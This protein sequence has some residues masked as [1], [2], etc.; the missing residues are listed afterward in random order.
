VIESIWGYILSEILITFRTT[1]DHITNPTFQIF[2]S[3][4]FSQQVTKF[5]IKPSRSL[6]IR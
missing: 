3:F 5:V 1:F 6:E 2:L 4:L